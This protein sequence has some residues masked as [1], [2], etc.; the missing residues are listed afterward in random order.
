MKSRSFEACR[1]LDKRFQSITA[2]T[3]FERPVKGWIKAIREALGMTLEQLGNR[4]KVS[5][6]QVGYLEQDEL[7]GSVTLATMERIANALGC[8]FVYA[9]IPETSLQAKVHAQA[10][11]KALALLAQTSHSMNLEAQ[12]VLPEEQEEQLQRLIDDF[13]T[14]K[15]SRLWEDAE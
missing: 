15:P 11:Q 7:K 5:R 12:G 2:S 8:R 1:Q 9:L 3:L 13:L 4:M 6:Q 14:G 10:R